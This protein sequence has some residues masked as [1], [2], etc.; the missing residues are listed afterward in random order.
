MKNNDYIINDQ[1]RESEVRV[2]SEEGEMLGVMPTA[3]ALRKADD[4]APYVGLGR[5]IVKMINGAYKYKVEFL[6]KVK[7]A[8]PS[9]DNQTKGDGVEFGTTEIT[10]SIAALANG[11]WSIAK[12][13]ETQEDAISY[14]ESLLTAGSH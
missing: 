8:E 3:E 12:T 5:V 6:Y 4:A 1:I 2:I 9:Q 14:L 11:K 7:F 10:G 13:F